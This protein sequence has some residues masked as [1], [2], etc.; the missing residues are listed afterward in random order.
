LSDTATP[1]RKAIRP[2][3]G[4][5]FYAD[6]VR[7]VTADVRRLHG[8]AEFIEAQNAEIEYLYRALQTVRDHARRARAGNK[9]AAWIYSHAD[10]ALKYGE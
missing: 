7:E 10:F 4:H 6:Q 9:V 3:L 2:A 8:T 5:K 1:E